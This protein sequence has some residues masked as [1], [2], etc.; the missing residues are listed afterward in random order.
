MNNFTTTQKDAVLAEISSI[1][2]QWA[3]SGK[4]ADAALAD[5]DIKSFEFWQNACKE[6][7]KRADEAWGLFE[8]IE[9]YEQSLK[10]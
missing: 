1:N 7:H 8:V 9:A 6:C 2:T 4:M 5:N 10:A 3:E